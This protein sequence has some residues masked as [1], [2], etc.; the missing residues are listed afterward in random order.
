VHSGEWL[1]CFKWVKRALLNK[2]KQ[3]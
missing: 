2:P 3:T 1:V